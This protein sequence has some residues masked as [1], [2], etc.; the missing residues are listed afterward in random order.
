[1]R[2]SGLESSNSVWLPSECCLN[3]RTEERSVGEIVVRLRVQRC[4]Q[5]PPSSLLEGWLLLTLPAANLGPLHQA[6]LEL[7]VDRPS[8]LPGVRKAN[9]VATMRSWTDLF[10]RARPSSQAASS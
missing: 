2:S 3:P 7:G 4:F 6:A 1:M 9:R 8:R 5:P 10:S